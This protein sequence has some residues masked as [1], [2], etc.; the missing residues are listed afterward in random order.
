MLD[1][2]ALEYLVGLGKVQVIEINEQKYSPVGLNHVKV[3]KVE[4]IKVNSLTGLVDY[5]KS[6]FDDNAFDGT[7][8]HV[9]SESQ[10]KL[11]SN[12]LED[13]GRETYMVAD[14][15]SPKFN[16]G[17]W[18][19]VENFIIAMQ[20]C[21]VPNEDSGRLLRVVGNI[22]EENIRQSGD[23]GVSQQVTAKTGIATVENIK[24]PNPIV[25]A[26]FRTFVEIKQPESKFV[27][28][29]QQGPRCA[30]FEADGG[31]WRLEAMARIKAFLEAEL[32]GMEIPIIS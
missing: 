5:L 6:K 17:Q 32:D 27:F 9:V 2:K 25:L 7:M 13:S 10:V 22:K 3:P 18:Y 21:F 15:F 12:I 16:F 20:S 1:Q 31:A 26:P 4:G 19:D 30:L 28:R 24:V 11:V 8:V 14:A 29:M 23:D